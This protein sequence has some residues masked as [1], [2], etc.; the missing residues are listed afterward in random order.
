MMT[1]KQ[2]ILYRKW[3]NILE[4]KKHMEELILKLMANPATEDVHMAQAHAMYADVCK[5]LSDVSHHI[6]NVLRTGHTTGLEI[7]DV[8]CGCGY[9][10]KRIKGAAYRCPEC[11]MY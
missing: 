7:E 11:G 1:P 2:S 10:G 5:R 6:D 9:V 3:K 4:N 8:T